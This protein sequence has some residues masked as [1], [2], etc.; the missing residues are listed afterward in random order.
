MYLTMSSSRKNDIVSLLLSFSKSMRN[1]FGARLPASVS[2][3]QIKVLGCVEECAGQSMKCVAEDLKV[4]PAAI[5]IIIDKLAAD[6]LIN[7]KTDAKDKR[8]TRLLLT[9][10][11]RSTLRRGMKIFRAHIEEATAVLSP[12]EKIQLV[13]ILTK[14]INKK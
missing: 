8:V 9:A 10:K 11:G 6:G 1:S 12:A 14:L 3:L 4:T 5:T 13:S 7:K 2:M